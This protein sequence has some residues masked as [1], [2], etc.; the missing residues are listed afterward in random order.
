MKRKK[1]Y[2]KPMTEVL[3]INMSSVMYKA[4]LPQAGDDEIGGDA[5][6]KNGWFEEE[7]DGDMNN[8][9]PWED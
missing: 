1:T 4:S 9:S 3:L 8:H 7:S 2:K 5:D 6:A